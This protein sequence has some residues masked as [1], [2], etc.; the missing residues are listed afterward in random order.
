MP[1]EMR[2]E[3]HIQEVLLVSPIPLFQRLTWRACIFAKMYY[4]LLEPVTQ[5][6]KSV[7]VYA[8]YAN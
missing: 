1:R 6:W 8:E 4:T 5:L 2:H 3:K 7:N